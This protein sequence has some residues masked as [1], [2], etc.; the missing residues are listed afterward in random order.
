MDALKIKYQNQKCLIECTT[1]QF[2]VFLEELKEKLTNRFFY[3][4]GYFEAFFSFPFDLSE[5]QCSDLY[6]ICNQN[7]TYIMGIEQS[8]K[9]SNSILL[10]RCFFNGGEY[11]L[12]TECVYVGDIDKDVHI[13][14]SSNLYVIGKIKGIVDLLHEHCELSASSFECAKIRIFDSSFQNVTNCAPCKV[15]YG[16]E[17]IQTQ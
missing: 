8:D 9:N 4:E 17:G 13:T 6:T 1:A 2:H 12:D 3:K 7:N 15:Y 10:E 14:T 5:T 11:Y 16:K